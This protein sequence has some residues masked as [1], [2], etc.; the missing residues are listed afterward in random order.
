M[1]FDLNFPKSSCFLEFVGCNSTCRLY[2]FT[3]SLIQHIHVIGNKEQTIAQTSKMTCR[4]EILIDLQKRDIEVLTKYTT[5]G[6]DKVSLYNSTLQA[7]R[8][9]FQV[10]TQESV[11]FHTDVFHHIFPT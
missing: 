3:G 5:F 7:L 10:C 11:V 6:S 2:S 4:K 1:S 9:N 8:F